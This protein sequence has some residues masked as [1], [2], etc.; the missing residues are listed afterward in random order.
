[1]PSRVEGLPEWLKFTA[2]AYLRWYKLW[3]PAY[4][5]HNRALALQVGNQLCRIA[6]SPLHQVYDRVQ[7]ILAA[8]RE[9][10]TDPV[11]LE[12][13]EAGARL[14]DL[15]E[16]VLRVLRGR[17]ALSCALLAVAAERYRLKHGH[18]PQRSDD[19]LPDFLS[20][21]PFDPFDGKPLRTKRT[22][23]GIIIYSVGDN[24]RDDAGDLQNSR[25]RGLYLLDP[26][27]RLSQS[28]LNGKNVR[29]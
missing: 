12:L 5:L 14:D 10:I 8:T 26:A 1:M 6:D 21:V 13:F 27:R 20:V 23:Q 4:A 11:Q 17:A 16:E 29:P 28:I 2:P 9:A 24:G 3:V 15:L 19:L 25:D 18:W 22:E 7:E